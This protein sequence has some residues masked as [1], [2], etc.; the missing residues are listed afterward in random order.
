MLH[1]KD[2]EAFARIN[3][4]LARRG[5][6]DGDGTRSRPAA[7]EP[8]PEEDAGQVTGHGYTFDIQALPPGPARFFGRFF[9]RR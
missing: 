5:D 1:I 4:A 7:G 6:G 3:E 2:I 9:R 8:Q